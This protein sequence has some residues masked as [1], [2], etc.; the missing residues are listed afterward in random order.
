VAYAE[1][2]PQE[3]RRA[4]GKGAGQTC[5]VERLNSAQRQARFIRRTLSFSKSDARQPS[6]LHEYNRQKGG[7]PTEHQPKRLGL[8]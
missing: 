2:L 4:G 8:I 7:Q 6:A 1:V 3:Q 5:R